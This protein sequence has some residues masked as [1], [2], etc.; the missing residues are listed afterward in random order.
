MIVRSA[1]RD[2]LQCGM[3]KGFRH[4]GLEQFYTSGSKRGIVAEHAKRLAYILAALDAAESPHELD[5][6]GFRLHPLKGDLKG[7]WAISV[8]GN[9]RIVFSFNKGNAEDIDYVDYH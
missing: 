4:K 1:S 9:W 6:P 5:L 3:I 2:V 7:Y 8:R